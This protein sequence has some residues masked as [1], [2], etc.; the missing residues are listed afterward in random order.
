M[1]THSLISLISLISIIAMSPSVGAV[2]GTGANFYPSPP[3]VVSIAKPQADDEAGPDVVV[4]GP[5]TI[6]S[7]GFLHV[8][9]RRRGLQLVWPQGGGAAEIERGQYRSAGDLGRRP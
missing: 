9:A 3:C 5:A 4:S 1:K 2:V 7:N 8:F 6:P